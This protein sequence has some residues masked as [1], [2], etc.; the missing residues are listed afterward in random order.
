MIEHWLEQI[1]W[2][3]VEDEAVRD[4]QDLLRIDTTNPPG[5]EKLA[6]E[7]IAQKL[8]ADG[9]EPLVLDSAKDRANMVVR[10]TGT[11]D[12]PPLLLSAHLDVVPAEGN[13][14]HPPFGGEIADGF[15]WGRGAIDMKNMAIM[16]LWTM[17][18]LARSSAKL[19][20]SVIFAAVADEE[21]GC[22]Y[23]SHWLVDHHADQIRAGYALSEVGGFSLSLMGRRF[24]PIQVAE[25]G[26]VCIEMQTKGASGHG[27][28]PKSNSAVAKLARA[29]DR[30]ARYPLPLHLTPVQEDFLREV[31]THLPL[32]AR[33]AF[34]LLRTPLADYLLAVLPEDQAAAL[35]ACLHNTASPTVIRAGDKDNV[36]SPVATAIL[37]GR[38]LPGQSSGDLL[39]ELQALVGSDVDLK[40]KHEQAPVS[41]G[42]YRSDLYHLLCD[43]LKRRDPS[44]IPVP[45][46]LP[47][48][49]DAKAYQRLGIRCYGFAPI[50][51][52]DNMPF[53]SLF[54]A[55]DER[56]PII[57]FHWGLRT[58]IET[59][60]RFAEITA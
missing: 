26:Q 6:A 57:G 58:L 36:I 20:R 19:K 4:L 27:A 59:V 31:S 23:G 50:Q 7:Y 10:I 29:I 15:I 37:D 17:K 13:W 46:L 38:T 52:S 28:I 49:T 47:G 11:S 53:T 30:I 18:L 2:R 60:S 40:V 33:L 32:P 21:A 5:G 56:I 1:D 22:R 42:A 12:L 3:S 14:S 48:F 51:L 25:K 39:R 16:C 24:Y 45:Q 54:H 43:V 35:R 55:V 41:M 9:L 44:G 34:S 8:R